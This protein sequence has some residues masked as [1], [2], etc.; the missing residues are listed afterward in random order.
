MNYRRPDMH[1]HMFFAV[2][3]LGALRGSDTGNQDRRRVWLFLH[4]RFIQAASWAY[5]G[6]GEAVVPASG[7]TFPGAAFAGGMLVP[8]SWGAPCW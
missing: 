5:F 2:I 3:M 7:Y 4:R 6:G 1:T 8:G